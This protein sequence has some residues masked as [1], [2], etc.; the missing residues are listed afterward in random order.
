[1]GQD[2]W[3]LAQDRGHCR[4]L[5]LDPGGLRLLRLCHL[6]AQ[7][8]TGSPV[9]HFNSAVYE[10]MLRGVPLCHCLVP[11]QEQQSCFLQPLLG[12]DK[13]TKTQFKKKRYNFPKLQKSP[14]DFNKFLFHLERTK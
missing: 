7:S 10:G 5:L 1:M 13:E 8:D 12:G 11:F 14:S 3:L 4:E 2:S 9:L 6:L